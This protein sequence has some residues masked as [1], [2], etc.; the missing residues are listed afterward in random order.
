[1]AMLVRRRDLS[2]PPIQRW[3]PFPELQEL[4][5]QMAQLMERM[6][7]GEDGGPWVPAVD[8]EEA[9]DAWIVEA[10]VPGAKRDDVDVEVRDSE[11][12]ITGEIKDREREGVMRRRTRRS[13]RFEFRVTLPGP[14][15]PEK[16]QAD[17]DDGVLRLRIPKPEI[18]R[19]RHVEVGSGSGQPN[20]TSGP[21]DPG[22]V[23]EAAIGAAAQARAAQTRQGERTGQSTSSAEPAQPSGST[24]TTGSASSTDPAQQ[25]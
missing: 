20:G 24:Q 18:A 22:A 1:M 3:Q 7:S 4:Q 6:V 16:V 21:A 17:L 12:A 23:A 15:D 11:I 14:T 25:R 9:D 8:I 5:E 2:A 13:G 19:P 10:E